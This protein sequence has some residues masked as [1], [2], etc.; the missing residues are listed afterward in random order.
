MVEIQE[1]QD[2]PQR[3]EK[4]EMNHYLSGSLLDPLFYAF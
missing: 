3:G 2:K 1:N 4:M